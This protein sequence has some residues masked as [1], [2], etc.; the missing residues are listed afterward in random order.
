MC[1]SIYFSD[2]QFL[3]E[4]EADYGLVSYHCMIH[5]GLL[6]Y[7][8]IGFLFNCGFYKSQW[9]LDLFSTAE[10]SLSTYYLSTYPANRPIS[11]RCGLNWGIS[12]SACPHPADDG[13]LS[14]HITTS[15]LPCPHMGP[16]S[17]RHQTFSFRKFVIRFGLLYVRMSLEA[18]CVL[19]EKNENMLFQLSWIPQG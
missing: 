10:F 6:S 11:A 5:V 14:E 19:E 16:I 2:L 12:A 3:L 18:M 8:I 13:P 17:G 4:L 15:Y 1:S 7:D 9:T